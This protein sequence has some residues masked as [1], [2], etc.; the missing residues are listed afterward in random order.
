MNFLKNKHIIA[1][2]IIAPILAV[3][4]W[5]AVDYFV[6][7]TPHQIKNGEHYKMLVKPNCRWASGVCELKNNDVNFKISSTQKKHTNTLTLH[8]SVALDEVNI[9]IA[10][11]INDHTT[12]QKMLDNNNKNYII[13]FD[14]IDNDKFLQIVAK[15]DNSIFYAIVPTIFI[16]KEQLIYNK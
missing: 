7:E 10:D 4:S 11:N 3:M 5:F 8:S 16:H 9:A 6:K 14:T 1:A 15:I 13:N 12:P 2:M